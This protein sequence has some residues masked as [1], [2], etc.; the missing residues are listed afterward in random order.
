MPCFIW[1]FFSGKIPESL[2]KY[3]FNAVFL[4][5]NRFTGDGSMFF[6]RNKTTIQLDLSRNM[7]QFD[8]SKV[9]IAR[10]LLMLDLSQNRI[11]GKIPRVL[12]TLRRLERF[13][14]SYNR[15]CGK[16]PSGGRLQTFEPSAYSHNLCLCGT[17]LKACWISLMLA[18]EKIITFNHDVCVN[19]HRR[20]C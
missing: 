13:N 19:H 11:F 7:F 4:S 9:K 17:P 1:H 8:L 6:G 12:T 2:S 10:S 3:D 15:L 5:G 14:V 18:D 16:I 20:P